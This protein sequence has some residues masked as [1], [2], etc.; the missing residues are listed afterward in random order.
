MASV[1][2]GGIEVHTIIKSVAFVILPKEL[3]FKT[4]PDN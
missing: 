2:I 1:D 3:R 4:L